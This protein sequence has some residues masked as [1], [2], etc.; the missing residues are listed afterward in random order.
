MVSKFDIKKTWL[1]LKK[2]KMLVSKMS[3]NWVWYSCLWTS[4]NSISSLFLIDIFGFKQFVSIIWKG[5]PFIHFILG[6]GF[7][8]TSHFIHVKAISLF[9]CWGIIKSYKALPSACLYFGAS[10]FSS[11]TNNPQ[12]LNRVAV[13][14]VD[15]PVKH[16]K[17]YS[18]SSGAGADVMLENGISI[19]IRLL[20]VWKQ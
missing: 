17:L 4:F 8:L 12:I 1:K 2:R 5:C 3:Q 14:W 19:S 18:S 16:G 20:C 13:R 9:H 10:W 15:C 6:L 7:F 11:L